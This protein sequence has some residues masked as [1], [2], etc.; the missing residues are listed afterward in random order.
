M[1]LQSSH[2]FVFFSFA[3]RS[4]NFWFPYYHAVNIDRYPFSSTKH[5]FLILVPPSYA[6][7]ITSLPGWHRGTMAQ[8]A[9]ICSDTSPCLGSIPQQKSRGHPTA[10]EMLSWCKIVWDDTVSPG[11][12]RKA[13]QSQ[14]A[15][16]C[17]LW[18]RGKMHV[19]S[20]TSDLLCSTRGSHDDQ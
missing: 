20:E 3:P 5:I 2:S 8:Q 6:Y 1:I 14:M 9:P 13:T 16:L 17:S 7:Y 15:P 10:K 4:L 12:Q 11:S 19:L 18:I